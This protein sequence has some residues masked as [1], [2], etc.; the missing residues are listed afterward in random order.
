MDMSEDY[1][2]EKSLITYSTTMGGQRV[3]DAGEKVIYTARCG[4]QVPAVY[5]D[6]IREYLIVFAEKDGAYAHRPTE[7]TDATDITAFHPSHKDWQV[8][9]PGRPDILKSF[10]KPQNFLDPG[11]VVGFMYYNGYLV[12]DHECQPLRAFR[13][14]PL[15]LS[16]KLEGWRAEAIRRSDLR[17]RNMD[18]IA[19]M[20]VKV[21]PRENGISIREPLVK[22]NAVAGRQKRFREQVGA[23]TWLRPTARN[24]HDFLWSLLPKR[25][26][27]NNPSLPR[28]LTQ[29]ERWQLKALNVGKRPDRARKVPNADKGMTREQYIDDVHQRAGTLVSPGASSRR[30]RKETARMAMR[31]AKR[32]ATAD[33][34]PVQDLA[35]LLDFA[36]PVDV[37]DNPAL[38]TCDHFHEISHQSA[39]TASAALSA[40]DVSA[41]PAATLFRAPLVRP[42][43]YFLD[44]SRNLF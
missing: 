27:E 22:V 31:E 26:Q 24:V 33:A 17:I 38:P 6:Q 25:C 23:I 4:A 44:E 41:A 10:A 19:R 2:L 13:G 28:D 21:V 35:V 16:S 39:F 37:A 18:L 42:G 8:N 20:P 30:L 1:I 11:Y 12:V 7:G 43:E 40:F 34:K 9:S 32:E 3:I 14:L 29:Q 15:T 5:H 36:A